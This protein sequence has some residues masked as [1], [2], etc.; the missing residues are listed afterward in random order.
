M[1]PSLFYHFAQI[2]RCLSCSDCFCIGI[3]EIFPIWYLWAM[4]F[5]LLLSWNLRKL[6]LTIQHCLGMLLSRTF[7]FPSA[8]YCHEYVNVEQGGCGEREEGA[9]WG[10]FFT[11]INCFYPKGRQFGRIFILIRKQ[12]RQSSNQ[13][14][15]KVCYWLAMSSC[16]LWAYSW[17]EKLQPRIFNFCV[18][19]E[20]LFGEILKKV[21]FLKF[22]CMHSF[23]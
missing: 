14:R 2:I 8:V 5:K 11:T 13:I 16:A 20:L 15:G 3:I 22:W 4:I 21:I 9:G 17:G 1:L 7:F 6:C 18:L 12:K 10:E 19:K 23:I